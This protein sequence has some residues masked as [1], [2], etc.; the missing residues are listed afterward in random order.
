MLSQEAYKRAI[1]EQRTQVQCMAF[2]VSSI[3]NPNALEKF[4]D[5][6]E[7]MLEDV[8]PDKQGDG[9]STD[10]KHSMRELNKLTKFFKVNKV[11]KL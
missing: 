5:E 1:Q 8:D 7:R 4:F 11:K 10:M 3:F 6:T 9:M 2:A